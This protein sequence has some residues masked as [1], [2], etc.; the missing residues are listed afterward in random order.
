MDSGLLSGQP[1]ANTK[2]PK[3]ILW[4]RKAA[5][6]PQATETGNTVL[7]LI[8]SQEAALLDV[9]AD[10]GKSD[11]RGPVEMP[12]MEPGLGEDTAGIGRTL[13]RKLARDPVG[14]LQ[15]RRMRPADLGL[16][17]R[18]RRACAT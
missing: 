10:G 4:T 8:N 16:G 9:L 18:Q 14:R 6:K 15:R 17:E 3:G 13:H 2:C 7:A 11:G 5:R 1:N 12:L